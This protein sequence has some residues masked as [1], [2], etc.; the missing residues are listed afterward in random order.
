LTHQSGGNPALGIDLLKRMKKGVCKMVTENTSKAIVLQQG[1]G[2]RLGSGHGRDLV[3][4]LTG[5]QTGGAF[6]YLIVDVPSGNGTPLHV[7]H[8]QDETLHILAGEFKVQLGEETFY[9]KEGGF[10]YLPS[11]VPHA[12]INISD[13]PGQAIIVYTPGGA[14]KFFEEFGP[15]ARSTSDPK[16]L[17]AVLEKHDMALLGPPLSAD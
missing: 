6:D 9:L 15:I 5:E 8:I 11:N 10:A 17:G 7:H 3:F 2:L 13:K 12:F 14:D 4:K 1:E 16:V